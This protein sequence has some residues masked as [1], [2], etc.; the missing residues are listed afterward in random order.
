MIINVPIESSP[1]YLVFPIFTS[2]IFWIY[3][4]FVIIEFLTRDGP[5][6]TKSGVMVKPAPTPEQ[7]ANRPPG[8]SGK[9]SLDDPRLNDCDKA[10][11]GWTCTRP[12]GHQGSCAAQMI[13]DKVTCPCCHRPYES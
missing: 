5:R 7:L 13:A 11:P 4:L 9:S 12:M 10:P 2:I 8:V 6:N 1:S 3:L